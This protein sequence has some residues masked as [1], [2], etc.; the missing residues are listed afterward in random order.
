MNKIF[1]NEANYD[2]D[3]IN[4]VIEVLKSDNK[5]LVS[6][7]KTIQFE[8][9]ISGI[10]GRKYGVFVNSGSSANLLALSSL[11]IERSSEIITPCLTFATTIAPILQLGLIPS[12]VDIDLRSLNIDV[13][14]IEKCINKKTKAMF[15]PNLIGNLPNWSKIS[16]IAKKYELHVIEDSADTI[17][18]KYN[19][20]NSST[21]FPFPH[22]PLRIVSANSLISFSAPKGLRTGRVSFLIFIYLYFIKKF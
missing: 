16:E 17:G 9:E 3:E 15:I 11:E 18:Y 22:H 12:L 14:Q 7:T 4:A 5:S 6:G 13:E 19:G 1:Y 21:F 20:S 2:D 10:F 8:K